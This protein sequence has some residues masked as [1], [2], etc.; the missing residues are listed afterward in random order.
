MTEREPGN[1]ELSD[2]LII[3]LGPRNEQ[4]IYHDQDFVE[5]GTSSPLDLRPGRLC[6]VYRSCVKTDLIEHFKD[7]S[8][9]NYNY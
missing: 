7:P 6:T 5:R 2:K 9:M 8:V 3:S 1:G 4:S